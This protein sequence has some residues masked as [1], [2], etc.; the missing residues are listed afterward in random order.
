MGCCLEKKKQR[1]DLIIVLS[2]CEC[3]GEEEGE[4]LFSFL[5]EERETT[6]LIPESV[7]LRLEAHLGS[8]DLTWGM[9]AVGREGGTLPGG[10]EE[11]SVGPA[12]HPSPSQL[13]LVRGHMLQDTGIRSFRLSGPI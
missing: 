9:L 13:W 3:F 6:G 1:D 10:S 7:T 11:F 2:L 4:Q 5:R 8:E 12:P